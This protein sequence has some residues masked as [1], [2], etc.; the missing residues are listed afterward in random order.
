MSK[1]IYAKYIRLSVDDA[2]SD[3]MS[4]ENQRLVID[5]HLARLEADLADLDIAEFVDNGH[6]GT[7]FDRPAVQKLLELVRSG[8]VACIIVKDFSR[9][10]RNSLEMGY[11]IEKVFP[12]FGVRFI[13]VSDSFDSDDHK[14]STG[15]LEV[16]FKYLLHEYYSIDLSNK[17]RAARRSR[18]ESGKAVTK[19][20]VFGY[21]LDSGRN[22]VIDEPAAD[23]VRLIFKLALEGSS[24][25]DIARRLYEEKRPTPSLYK[26]R[27][28]NSG[29]IWAPASI[30]SF[31]S[32]EQ[33]AGT[34]IA[35]RS[36]SVGIGGK[37]AVNQ[38]E[39]EWIKIP[40]HH[41]AIIEKPLFDKVQLINKRKADKSGKVSKSTRLYGKREHHLKN[42]VVCGCC[43]RTMH[44]SMTRNMRFV[45]NYTRS[46]TDMDCHK[47]GIAASELCDTVFEAIVRQA[48]CS[49]ELDDLCGLGELEIVNA[50]H[51]SISSQITAY[52]DEKCSLYESYVNNEIG[53]EDYRDRKYFIDMEIGR[54]KRSMSA[55]EGESK[56]I[57]KK[58]SKLELA[59]IVTA[60]SGLTSQLADLLIEKVRLY[61]NGEIEIEWKSSALSTETEVSEYA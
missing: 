50:R 40:D 5:R 16:T 59:G 41:P 48:E 13:S 55:L 11:F 3:S 2:K 8:T 58:N 34:Y 12:L 26:G 45:C 17:I 47:Y 6:S 46:A 23:T 43:N 57:E 21:M 39:S 7:D 56:N 15:G 36:R 1:Q 53:A 32:E 9:F 10:G 35:G 19:N 37:S 30:S 14:G 38:P 20:C 49:D 44:L 33:Y 31:L 54:L 22:M 60:E 28:K 42:K 29:Y 61:P 24:F 18:M 25:A 51:N 4:I 27:S 52:D